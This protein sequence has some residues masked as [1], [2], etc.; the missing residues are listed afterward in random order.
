MGQPA[1]LGLSPVLAQ[2]AELAELA[3]LAQL[4]ELLIAAAPE[5]VGPLD[6]LV[7]QPTPFCNLD[8]SYCYLP[9]RL[10]RDRISPDTLDRLFAWVFSSGLARRPFT[11]V[12]HAGEPMVLPPSFYAAAIDI[13]AR[14]N[15][16]NLPVAHHFQTNATLVDRDWCDFLRATGVNVGVSVDGPAFLNDRCRRTRG[17]RGTHARVLEGIARL[18]EAAIPFHVISVLTRE[19]LDYPDEIFD[20]FVEQGF[21][22]VGFNVE[23]IEGPNQSSSLAGADVDESYRRFLSRFFDL[24]SRSEHPMHVR[25]FDSMIAAILNES[26]ERP[27]THETVPFAIVSVDH[28]GRLATF[29]PELLGLS[30]PRYGDLSLGSVLQDS[31]ED[32]LASPRFAAIG[33][34]VAAGVERCAGECAYFRF[35]G[36]GAPANKVFENGSFDSTETLFCRLTRKAVLDVVLARMESRAGADRAAPAG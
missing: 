30:A 18:R 14:H 10:N 28:R 32:V 13:I 8:C 5:P 1:Q 15:R 4:G 6:L 2:L 20:F 24:V 25:E 19:S 26:E 23:E 9:D 29:S 27:R 33:G 12:W 35:C 22:R 11:V 21:D 16:G 7:V 36:G 3:Q 34:D 17:G 31:L